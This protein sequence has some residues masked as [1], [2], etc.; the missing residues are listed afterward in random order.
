M[1]INAMMA[2]AKKMQAEMEKAQ[3]EIEKKEFVVEKQGTKVTMLGNFKIK[4]IEI[5]EVLIDPEDK[6]LLEDMVLIT[7]N[8]AIELVQAEKENAAPKMPT[9]MPF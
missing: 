2:Q 9:G 8:E 3:A 6:D 5:N 4:K 1:N 7:V